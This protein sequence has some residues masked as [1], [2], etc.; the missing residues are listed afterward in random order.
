MGHSLELLAAFAVALATTFLAVPWLIPKLKAKGMIGHDL[1]KRDKPEVA[2][3]GGVAVVIGF[4]AGVSVGIALDGIERSD[5]LNV[6][7]LAVLGAA[8]IGMI[9]DVFELRQRQKAFFPFLLALPLGAALD[10]SVYIPFV[11]EVDLGPWMLLAAPFAVTCAANAGNMLEGFNGLGAGLGII[12]SSTLI[13]LALIHDRLDGAYILV[14][15]LGALIAFIWFN[16]YP[17]KVFPGDT[18]MLFMGASLAVAGMLSQLYIQTAIIF[19]PMILE[20]FLKLRG[21]FKAEN[22]AT[23][24][25]NGHLEYSGKTESITHVF[26]KRLKVDEKKLVVIIWAIEAV[27]CAVVVG[28]DLAV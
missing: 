17:S 6:S 5:I 28:V 13:A 20:F 23:D 11:G 4:F 7:L 25:S 10:P 9:D 27:I 22:Y 8:F 15:L 3:M 26:M 12:M 21:G 19:T 14:P 24:A 2:E 16:K 18:L 1:N